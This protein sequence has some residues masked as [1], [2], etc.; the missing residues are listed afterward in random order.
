MSAK[1]EDKSGSVD[2]INE[3]TALNK[4]IKNEVDQ[5]FEEIC[6]HETE[7]QVSRVSFL[8]CT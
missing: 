7:R 3:E 4:I 8:P 6:S 2:C 1:L 5:H